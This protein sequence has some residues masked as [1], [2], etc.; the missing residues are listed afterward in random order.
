MVVVATVIE[1]LVEFVAALEFIMPLTYFVEVLS[2]VV[3]AVAVGISVE[4]LSVV[5][6][7]VST[8]VMT[9]L[10]LPMSLP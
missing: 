1:S 7:N 9:A 5:N 3:V 4:L 6:I 10:E 8:A 2:D